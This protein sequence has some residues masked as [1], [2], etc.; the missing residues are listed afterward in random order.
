MHISGKIYLMSCKT[1]FAEICAK[2]IAGIS[3]CGK[4]DFMGTDLSKN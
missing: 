4:E 1:V 3:Q 2:G